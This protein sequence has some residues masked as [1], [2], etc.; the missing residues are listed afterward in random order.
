MRLYKFIVSLF[1]AL[2]CC[3]GAM[4]QG[5]LQDVV[6]LKNGSI[7]RGII[8][9]QVPFQS[10]KIKTMDGSVF[11]YNLSEV[12]KI[13]KEEN[14][15]AAH[16][17]GATS[18][19]WDA[20]SGYK[21]FVDFGYTI[22]TND[23]SGRL[24]ILTTHGF[25]LIPNYLFLGAGFGVQYFTDT[26]DTVLGIPLFADVRSNFLPGRVSPLFDLKIGYAGLLGDYSFGDGGL[27]LAP[28]VGVQVKFTQRF[29]MDFLF[30]Y[31]YQK[32]ST[33]YLMYSGG[34]SYTFEEKDNVGGVHL[35]LGIEF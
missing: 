22:G 23:A 29:A 28:S 34:Y 33:Y 16:H 1:F 9:E 21:G 2:L 18:T 13:T 10:L 15:M 31:T 24:E 17:I 35:K 8:V 12:S 7:I 27:Y 32:A 11:F 5:D 25:Q 14:P 4:A 3:T 20:K 6:Y 19:K 30:G 26:D